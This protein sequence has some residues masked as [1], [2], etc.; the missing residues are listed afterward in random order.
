MGERGENGCRC[1]EI[2]RT[3]GV[4][5]PRRITTWCTVTLSRSVSGVCC[6]APIL[7]DVGRELIQS[8]FA[9]VLCVSASFHDFGIFFFPSLPLL[10]LQKSRLHEE[11]INRE[12][13]MKLLR[14]FENRG[15]EEGKDRS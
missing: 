8:Y 13:V 12:I 1:C 10:S 11:E 7:S 2:N 4:I 3:R 5:A 15:G 6:L 14:N 9:R